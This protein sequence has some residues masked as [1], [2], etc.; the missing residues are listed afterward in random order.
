MQPHDVLCWRLQTDVG[1]VVRPKRGRTVLMD[2][3]VLHRV[4]APSAS[5]EGRPRY[6]LVWKLVGPRPNAVAD[7][8]SAASCSRT[9]KEHVPCHVLPAGRMLAASVCLCMPEL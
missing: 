1:M 6:S 5:A 2:Q 4:S 8:R 9:C 3:D 7:P